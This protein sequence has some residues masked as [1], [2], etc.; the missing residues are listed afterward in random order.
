MNK[1]QK[2][3]LLLISLAWLLIFVG[4]ITPSTLLVNITTDLGISDV[5]AGWAFTGMWTMYGIMQFPGG[6]LS[7]V[8]GRKIIITLSALFFSIATFLTGF[9]INAISLV[10]TFSLIGMSAGILPAPS[11]TMIAELFGPRKGKALGIHSSIGSFSGFAPLIVPF[12]ALIL[13]WRNVFLLWGVLGVFLAFFLYKYITETLLEPMHQ[14]WKDRFITGLKGL[15][16][17][18]IL[19]MFIVNLVISFA[20]MGMLNWYPTYL[21]QQKG[22]SPEIAGLLFAIMMSGGLLFKPVIGHLSDR[23]NRLFIMMLL[24]FLAGVSLYFLT[25]ETS[26]IGLIIVS[27]LLSQTGAFYPIRTSYVM[28]FWDKETAGAKLG[29]FRSLIVLL[30]SPVTGGAIAQ[31]K[32]LYGFNTIILVVSAGLFITAGVLLIYLIRSDHHPVYRNPSS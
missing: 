21:Q 11:F 1:Y 23:I 17:K 12:I 30:G 3:S 32:E 22:F 9:N 19:F 28:D 5:Q 15:K 29:V 10:I 4:R 24:T 16:Q 6:V 13:G 18:E 31:G 14:N 26:V 7:D 25:I 2:S 20:W 8:Y 27:F